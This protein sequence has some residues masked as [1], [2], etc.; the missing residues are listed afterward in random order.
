M[1]VIVYCLLFIVISAKSTNFTTNTRYHVES[2]VDEPLWLQQQVLFSWSLEVLM[3][4]S[5][6]RTSASFWKRAIWRLLGDYV[7]VTQTR[8]CRGR[9]A[10]AGGGGVLTKHASCGSSRQ[11]PGPG[12]GV[13]ICLEVSAFILGNGSGLARVAS[14]TVRTRGDLV[15]F[16]LQLLTEVTA[17]GPH[18]HNSLLITNV[19]VYSV[20][21]IVSI[22]R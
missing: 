20:Y 17:S 8:G 9:E 18:S 22:I 12:P 21:H 15:P 11:L 16:T 3:S 13:Y 1:S 7:P 19:P 6:R 14:T 2:S 10:G 5:F 4:S